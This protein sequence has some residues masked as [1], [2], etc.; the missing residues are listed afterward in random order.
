MSL[1]FYVYVLMLLCI[2]PY[3]F[4][5]MSLCGKVTGQWKRRVGRLD[6]CF[7]GVRNLTNPNTTHNYRPEKRGSANQNNAKKE[8]QQEVTMGSVHIVCYIAI[9]IYICCI[10]WG[11]KSISVRTNGLKHKHIWFEPWGH[12][13]VNVRTQVKMRKD[14]RLLEKD[15]RFLV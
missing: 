8:T 4:M 10:P 11:Y 5:F 9:Y 14:M 1:C 6:W 2:C 3:A 15:I 12:M 13:S 7:R